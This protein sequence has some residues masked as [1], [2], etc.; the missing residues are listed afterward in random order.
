MPQ[1][2][3]EQRLA[4]LNRLLSLGRLDLLKSAQLGK[5]FSIDIIKKYA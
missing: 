3:K 1:V 5:Q 2:T 4:T